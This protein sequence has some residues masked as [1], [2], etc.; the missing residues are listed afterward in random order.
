MIK[1]SIGIPVYNQV[2]T[3]KDTIESALNQKKLPFEIIV[4][5]NHSTDGTQEIVEKYADRIKI[6]RP[7]THLSA[8]ENWNFCVKECQGD[9]VG[10]CSGDD[11]LFPNYVTEVL[12]AISK[13]SSAIFIMGG[14]EVLNEI[15]GKISTR[16]LLSMKRLTKPPEA[17]KMQLS[18]PKASFAAFCFNK[19]IFDKVGGFNSIY[20]VNFDWMLQFDMAKYG[21]FV[22]IDKIIARYRISKR[23][24]IKKERLYVYVKDLI[25]YLDTKIWEAL[26]FG[27]K[28]N[29]IKKAARKIYCHSLL[30]YIQQNNLI[31]EDGVKR[32]L[33]SIA[34]KINAEEDYNNWEKGDWVIKPEKSNFKT[35]IRRVYTTLRK[36]YFNER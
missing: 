36:V 29:Y 13:Y 5:E 32:Q 9:W 12:K 21:D 24:E 20:Y 2:N 4:S 10:L 6:V 22:K 8:S 7:P 17:L 1:L 25:R 30:T 15:E 23:D 31:I 18:G 14:W 26:D 34:L 3:I 16:Y 33:K 28:E 35:I 19:N 27:I 11:I